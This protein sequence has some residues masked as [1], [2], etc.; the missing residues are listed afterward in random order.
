M[1]LLNL[2][3]KY[4]QEKIK[5]IGAD[6]EQGNGLTDLLASVS[7]PLPG[8]CTT[9]DSNYLH[10]INIFCL[11]CEWVSDLAWLVTGPFLVL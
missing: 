7:T 10:G 5:C 2:L 4:V 3:N 8:I 6:F 9:F 11:I 1:E